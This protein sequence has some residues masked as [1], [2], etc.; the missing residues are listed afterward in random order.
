M[1]LLLLWFTG[2]MNAAPTS[3]TRH[4]VRAVCVVI[5]VIIFI[6][7]AGTAAALTHLVMAKLTRHPS[8]EALKADAPISCVPA[9][10]RQQAHAEFKELVRRLQHAPRARAL[11]KPRAAD[12]R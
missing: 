2:E 3:G 6:P 10:G 7:V 9:A 8:F 1:G 4:L 12:E 11:E 5:V